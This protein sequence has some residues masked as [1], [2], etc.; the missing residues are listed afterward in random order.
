MACG[1]TCGKAVAPGRFHL[2]QFKERAPTKADIAAQPI[3]IS[4]MPQEAP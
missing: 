4:N 1:L 3:A 2:N